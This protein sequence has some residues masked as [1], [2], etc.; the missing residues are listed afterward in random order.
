MLKGSR[1]PPSHRAS[2]QARKSSYKFIRQD[3]IPVLTSRDYYDKSGER[4]E[5]G[6]EGGKGR[7]GEREGE[8]ARRQVHLP[9]LECSE[10]LVQTGPCRST[11]RGR[12]SLAAAGQS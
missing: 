3:T 8:R 7:G 2:V 11:S 4:L 5:R 6:R 1:H 10:I 12:R 9:L